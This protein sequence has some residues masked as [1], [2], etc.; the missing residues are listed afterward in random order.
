MCRPQA[1][2]LGIPSKQLALERSHAK[3]LSW[4]RVGPLYLPHEAKTTADPHAQSEHQ[5]RPAGIY[6]WNPGPWCHF[7]RTVTQRCL[8]SLLLRKQMT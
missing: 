3:Y 5:I 4:P 1:S 8:S 6:T 2:E 7:E